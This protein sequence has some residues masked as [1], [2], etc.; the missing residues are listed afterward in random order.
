MPVIDIRNE[1]DDDGILK[2]KFDDSDSLVYTENGAVIIL[3]N[4]GYE[5]CICEDEGDILHLIEA[6]RQI[7]DNL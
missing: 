6:L 7:Y 5:L 2:Y 4:N 1:N 3:D